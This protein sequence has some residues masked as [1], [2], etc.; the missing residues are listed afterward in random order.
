MLKKDTNVPHG[1][2]CHEDEVPS[3]VPQGTERKGMRKRIEGFLIAAAAFT[4]AIL[5]LTFVLS[6]TASASNHDAIMA[7][8]IVG[9]PVDYG[10]AINPTEID[11]KMEY[12]TSAN[13]AAAVIGATANSFT[14]ANAGQ[15]LAVAV[16]GSMLEHGSPTAVPE[17]TYLAN[18]KLGGALEVRQPD[19]T[20][21]ST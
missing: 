15:N 12:S 1:N 9:H 14:N 2:S 16:I 21:P 7:Y 19:L 17:N 10:P 3:K 18:Q 13:F 4:V 20:R 6:G 8:V 11:D 5:A